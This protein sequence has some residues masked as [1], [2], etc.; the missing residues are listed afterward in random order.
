MGLAIA[1]AIAHKHQAILKVESQLQR[2]S[3]FILEMSML[4]FDGGF[5]YS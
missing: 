4:N 2:G 3:I 1:R 5:I